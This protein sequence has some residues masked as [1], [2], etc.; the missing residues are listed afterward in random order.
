MRLHY[1]SA[2]LKK[3]IY[4]IVFVVE[5]ETTEIKIITLRYVRYGEISG[6]KNDKKNDYLTVF[7]VKQQIHPNL[8]NTVK[9]CATITSVGESTTALS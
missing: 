4:Q 2:K 1:P 6:V 3:L 7:Q 9:T 8:G 5:Y